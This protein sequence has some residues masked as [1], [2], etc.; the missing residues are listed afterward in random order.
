MISNPLTVNIVAFALE[1]NPLMLEAIGAILE[2]DGICHQLFTSPDALIAA[3]HPD[4]HICII[5]YYLNDKSTGLEV[6]KQILAYN[7]GCF[8]II[9]SGQQDYRIV[10]ELMNNDANRYVVKGTADFTDKL[11]QFV[12]QGIAIIRRRF[13]T[14]QEIAERLLETKKIFEDARNNQ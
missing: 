9:I 12:Q 2:A 11:H 14:Y 8:V 1:D 6:M 4:V 10:A 5:D 13:T 7:P 3:L